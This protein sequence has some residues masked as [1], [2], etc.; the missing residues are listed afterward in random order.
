MR[1]PRSWYRFDYLVENLASALVRPSSGGFATDLGCSADGNGHT[2][3]GAQPITCVS[4]VPGRATVAAGKTSRAY[5]AHSYPTK[6]PPEAIEPYIGHFTAPGDVVLDPFCGSGMTGLAA[7]RRGRRAV[8]NDLSPLAV[9]LAFNYTA[10]CDAGALART[11]RLLRRELEAEEARHYAVRCYDCHGRGTLRYTIWS[12]VYRCPRC[13][14]HTTLWH[15][16]VDPARGHV[17]KHLT[18]RACG[19]KWRR[20]AASRVG[21]EPAWVAHTCSCRRGLRQRRPSQS[22]MRRAMNFPPPSPDLFAPADIVQPEREMYQRSALHLRG[23]STVAD[24]YTSRNLSA[25]ASLWRAIGAVRDKRVRHA[26]AFAFTNT[27]WHGTRMRRFNARGGHRPLTGTLFVPQLSAEA[28]VFEVFDH[29]IRQLTR[30]YAELTDDL[31]SST[32]DARQAQ[33]A[34]QARQPPGRTAASVAVRLGSATDLRWVPDGSIDYV[35]TDPPFGSNIFYADC[36]LV[37]ETW[38]G[39][40]ADTMLEAVVNRSR[41]PEQGGK[42]LGDYRLVLASAFSE[43]HRVLKAGKWATV[44]FQSSDGAVWHSIEHAAAAAG[45]E[46][47]SADLLDKVQQSM[48]GYKGRSGKENVASF[49]IVLHLYKPTAARTPDHWRNGFAGEAEWAHANRPVSA[50]RSGGEN[51]PAGERS[52]AAMPY[53][54]RSRHSDAQMQRDIV[55]GAVAEHLEAAQRSAT[56]ERT[57]PYLYSLSVRALLNSG[58]SLAGFSMEVLRRRL[59]RNFVERG[60]RWFT[61]SDSSTP[62]VEVDTEGR[63]VAPEAPGS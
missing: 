15:D 37:S 2:H 57:L 21:V 30:F 55:L 43:M 38:L 8:L 12:D 7:V 31:P 63:V 45:F 5:N 4:F 62:A 39:A 29:K 41:R 52:L 46:V 9:H 14:T 1:T 23:V 59:V 25:L 19:E 61:G 58:V 24:L 40:T 13:R 28:N 36:N 20:T 17:P 18:C 47:H 54:G 26:L 33:Q 3:A 11:W 49:D 27:A 10:A 42:T 16:A 35:F 50:P 56:V 60:G 51:G 34:R 48:K 44:V 32:A 22:E 53:L 6:V